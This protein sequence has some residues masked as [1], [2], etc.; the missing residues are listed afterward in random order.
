MS[1]TLVK[2]PRGRIGYY[3]V[4]VSFAHVSR[5][6]LSNLRYPSGT[7]VPASGSVI[8]G[9]SDVS[10]LHC[11]VGT[12]TYALCPMPDLFRWVNIKPESDVEFREVLTSEWKTEHRRRF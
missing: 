12:A 10:R 2:L 4:N 5:A 3:Y 6:I 7:I 1:I 8:D 11:N 9:V